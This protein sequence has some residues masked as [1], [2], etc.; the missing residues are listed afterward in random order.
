MPNTLLSRMPMGQRFNVGVALA[1]VPI[2][3]LCYGLLAYEWSTFRS[4]DEAQRQFAS[5]RA[6]L[7]AMETISAERE[8]TNSVLGEDLPI[9]ASSALALSRARSQSDESIATLVTTLRLDNCATCVDDSAKVARLKAKLSVARRNVDRLASLARTRRSDH[10]VQDIADQMV[11]IVDE[12][13]PIVVSGTSAVTRGDRNALDYLFMARLSAQLR[14]QAGRLGS[15]FTGALVLR[16]PLTL[17]EKLAL[18]RTRGRID[19]LQM[20]IDLRMADHPALAAQAFAAMNAQ[21]FSTGEPYAETVEALTDRSGG[22]NL[23][24]A[25]FAQ[26]YVATLR[27]IVGFRDATLDAAQQELHDNRVTAL[28]TVVCT[29]SPKRC[30]WPCWAGRCSNSAAT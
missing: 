8:S 21:Y 28:C 11:V 29:P 6:A 14:E 13:G 4:A 3:S 25:Q 5:L 1:L 30:C 2:L 26:H 22:A 9:P 24:T 17:D 18:E 19:Q 12:F 23:T 7:L 20:M 10:A 16:R 27:P 15:H